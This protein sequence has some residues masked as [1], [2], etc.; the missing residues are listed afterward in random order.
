NMSMNNEQLVRLANENKSLKEELQRYK[1]SGESPDVYKRKLVDLIDLITLF[2]DKRQFRKAS[3][4][5][6]LQVPESYF[7]KLLDKI[8]TDYVL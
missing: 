7:D 5:N 2:C 8:K 6:D 1:E 4:G 3:F